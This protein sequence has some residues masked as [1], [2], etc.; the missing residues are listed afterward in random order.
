[1]AVRTR[2]DL[3][4]FSATLALVTTGLLMTFSASGQT[5]LPN[6]MTL[7]GAVNTLDMIEA[8]Q[9]ALDTFIEKQS[10]WVGQLVQQY[11]G[12]TLSLKLPPAPASPPASGTRAQKRSAIARRETK[13]RRCGKNSARRPR[14][15]RFR[16]P[17]RWPPPAPGPSPSSAR[18]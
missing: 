13:P 4:L 14:N 11:R 3:V 10:V 8:G 9:M 16:A 7:P 12:A 6:G 5:P 17:G 15:G 1:M 2:A 18:Q